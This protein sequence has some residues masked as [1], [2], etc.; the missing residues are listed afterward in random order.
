MPDS[1]TH[2]PQHCHVSQHVLHAV[3]RSPAALRLLLGGDASIASQARDVLRGIHAHTARHVDR[4][5]R[6]VRSTY[7]VDH[8]LHVAAAHGGAAGAPS[9]VLVDRRA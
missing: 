3:L 6:L 5:E 7:A 2:E 8:I 1:Y 4:A 9:A